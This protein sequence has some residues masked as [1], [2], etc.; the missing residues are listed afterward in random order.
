ADR[1]GEQADQP[2]RLRGL[3]RAVP[4]GGDRQRQR[5][6]RG[7]RHRQVDR[8]R[9]ATAG[10]T[11]EPVGIG[12]AREQR[13]LE[14]HDR[15]RPHRRRA[16]KTGQHH[17][18]EHRLQHEHQRGTESDGR[19]ER[20]E[21]QGAPGRRARRRFAR[22]LIGGPHVL[23]LSGCGDGRNSG[24]LD[25][26]PWLSRTRDLM[27]AGRGPFTTR[28]SA[29][30]GEFSTRAIGASISR[31]VWTNVTRRRH[32]L[33]CGARRH[34]PPAATSWPRK[35]VTRKRLIRRNAMTELPRRSL[36]TGTVATT[37]AAAV[38]LATS[39]PARAAAPPAGMQAPGWYRYKVATFEITLLT[40]GVNRFQFPSNIL[41]N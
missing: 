37:A 8:D 5:K 40:D 9:R 18:G 29:A 16:A 22:W 23:A 30:H 2:E 20:C 36:L 24:R 32:D 14:E 3:R 11:R 21:Q 26:R 10:V 41:P 15:H 38:P 39:F 34:A 31:S 19:R 6:R 27:S 4:A 1:G 12:V 13:G 33:R 17:L 35:A 7:D 25:R 28:G